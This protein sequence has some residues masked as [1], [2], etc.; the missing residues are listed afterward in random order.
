MK[1]E[2]S[3]YDLLCL[4]LFVR[5]LFSKHLLS[6]ILL[7]LILNISTFFSYNP[8]RS[9]EYNLVTLLLFSSF[10]FFKDI[11]INCWRYF[12][13]G[14]LLSIIITYYRGFLQ[15]NSTYWYYTRFMGGYKDP[16]VFAPALLLVLLI[17]F[18]LNFF[19]KIFTILTIP[20]IILAQ[21]RAVFAALALIITN[22]LRRSILFFIS[23]VSLAIYFL[24]YVLA[25][26]SLRGYDSNRF[27]G[28][29]DAL[30]LTSLFGNGSTS[31]DYLVGHPPHSL[32]VRMISDIGLLPSLLFFVVFVSIVTLKKVEIRRITFVIDTGY[33]Y[34]VYVYTV[35]IKEGF[36]KYLVVLFSHK[37]VLC[38]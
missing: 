21:S 8:I 31:S 25:K 15:F 29:V 20:G 4:L 6:L 2:P 35:F 12:L 26:M 5:N 14:N 3:L 10:L 36:G 13:T 23:A 24:P 19:K 27:S 17:A 7:F 16:N 32:Y 11:N 28:Q 9:L 30:K 33:L 18:Q 1:N 37:L 22:K 38:Q 34:S